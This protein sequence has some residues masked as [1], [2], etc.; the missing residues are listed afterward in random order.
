MRS[1]LVR[2]RRMGSVVEAVGQT[3]LLRLRSVGREAPSVEVY[4]KLEFANP[5][6]SVKDRAALRMI[7][8]AMLASE[9][10][11]GKTLIDSTSGNT[12]VAYSL[13]GAALA[14]ASLA[15]GLQ[16]T[17][18]LTAAL[19]LNLEAVWSVVLAGL[20]FR[21]H[22][23]RR[24]LLALALMTLGGVALS[25]TASGSVALSGA[26]VVAVVMARVAKWAC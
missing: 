5:G 25:L 1:S 15:W 9:L 3:P 13:F 12:G 16:H 21:E 14:P 10:S 19:L 26:G 22:L 8:Q 7:Q 17:G 18:A 6:G 4:V 24:V 23:G 20:V 2:S 11:G